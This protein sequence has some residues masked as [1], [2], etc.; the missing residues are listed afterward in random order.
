MTPSARLKRLALGVE[1]LFTPNAQSQCECQGCGCSFE[2]G[3]MDWAEGS[4]ACPECKTEVWLKLV[5]K[6]AGT[7]VKALPG[8]V[9]GQRV[10][11]YYNLHNQKWSVK[12]QTGPQRGRVIGHTDIIT[13]KDV[14]FKVSEIGRQRVLQEQRK[15]VHAGCVGTLVSFGKGEAVGRRISYNPYKG[16]TFYDVATQKPVTQASGV[17]M[18][19]RA[20]YAPDTDFPD[21]W[22]A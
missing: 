5:S 17:V 7:K 12:A 3:P 15:N 20:V 16:P 22:D 6:E 14:V 18:L 13:L 8:D 2:P 1:A 9:V 10:F 11:V 19:D 21:G 4:T